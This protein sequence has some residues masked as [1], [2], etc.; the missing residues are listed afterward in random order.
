MAHI[1][2]A[3]QGTMGDL[4][5]VARIGTLMKERG[6][7]V[8]L[9]THCHYEEFVQRA[10][11]EFVALDSPAEARQ[12]SEDSSLLH[13][14]RGQIAFF[15]KHTLP[16][17]LR[18]YEIIREHCVTSDTI[19]VGSHL[20]ILG[21]QTAAEKL[22]VPLVRVFTAVAHMT[23]VPLYE[24]L[25]EFLSEDINRLRKRVGLPPVVDWPAWVR[26]PQCSIGAWP[27]WFAPPGPSW[28]SGLNL[29]TVGFLTFDEAETGSVSEDLWRFLDNGDP[30]I[31]IT[32]GT[33]MYLKSEFYPACV[34]ACRLL[35]CRGILVTRHQ[36][37][38][39]KNLPDQV[40]WFEF[41]PFASIMPR[42]GAVVH[43]GGMSTLTRA[44]SVGVPQ[45]SLAA[46]TDRPDTAIR[47]Q[48]LGVAEYLPPSQWQPELIAEALRR[49]TSSP[50]VRERCREMADRMRSDVPAEDIC[51]VVES[52]IP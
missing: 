23:G 39:P 16:R 12:Y 15:K 44:L 25:C 43:H 20:L 32:G 13:T 7:R 51:A 10:G 5:P 11:L 3:T 47:F 29:V 4:A 14:P 49:L 38:V 42:M 18:E 30:P 36:R 35:E 19:L 50:T 17:A 2:L 26:Y 1:L 6:H 48:R 37:L 21:S 28:P 52:L 45:L 22:G 41:L 40:K 34:G 33:S 46:G 9:I 24:V 8:T 27:G 31:L